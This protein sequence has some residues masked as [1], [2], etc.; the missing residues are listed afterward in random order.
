MKLIS[1]KE[2]NDLKYHI[3]FLEH[4][5]VKGMKWGVRKEKESYGR[6]KYMSKDEKAKREKQAKTKVSR[7]KARA[8][9]AKKKAEKDAARKEKKRKAILENP[10][11]LY[12]HRREFSQAEIQDALKRFEWEKKLSDYSKGRLSNGADYINTV[13]KYANNAINVYNTAARIARSTDENSNLP[14]IKTLKEIGDEEKEKR[15]R[16]NVSGQTAHS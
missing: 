14:I 16:D 3:D 8:E 7:A 13:F 6:R 15:R 10:T 11:L 12:K 1:E 4:H 5:G 2:W 9:K